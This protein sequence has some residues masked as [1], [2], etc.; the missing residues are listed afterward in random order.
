MCL[1]ENK[2][3]TMGGD[4][5]GREMKRRDMGEIEKKRK[6]KE[7]MELTGGERNLCVRHR[8]MHVLR[9]LQINS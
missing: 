1:W 7:G 2:A 8:Y 3:K 9:H 5:K 6:K 4:G